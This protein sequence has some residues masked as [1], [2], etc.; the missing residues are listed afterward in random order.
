MVRI[1]KDILEQITATA[2]AEEDS[3]DIDSW[4]ETVSNGFSEDDKMQSIVS[5]ANERIDKI[6]RYKSNFIKGKEAERLIR[7]LF[8]R[9]EVDSIKEISDTVL[10]DIIVD[11]AN[12]YHLD[13]TLLYGGSSKKR[14]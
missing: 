8:R 3:R 5:Y 2:F 13:S 12:E 1:E 11:I 10:R 7:Q 14:K 4:A 9:A 6:S